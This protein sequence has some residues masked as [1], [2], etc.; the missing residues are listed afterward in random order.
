VTLKLFQSRTVTPRLERLRS[1]SL[2][3]DLTPAELRIVDGLLHERDYIENEVI[4]DEGDEGQAIYI[5]IEGEVL[6][7]RQ[8][9]GENG[10]LA[11][12]TPGKFFGELALLDDEPRAAQ[13]VAATNC[14]L[15]VFF[16]ADFLGLLD[17][18]ARV[19]SKIGRQLA[20]HIGRRMREMALAAGAL[21]HL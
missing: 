19:A 4:F 20:R 7:R 12:L 9:M 6:I 11:L 17:T 3:V 5:V 8:G 2:F 1:L 16:R 13:A 10:K 15:A 21:Q 18:H 14:R